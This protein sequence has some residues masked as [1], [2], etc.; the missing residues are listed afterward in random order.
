VSLGP[1]FSFREARLE[2]R[3]GQ[4]LLDSVSFETDAARVA[5][6]GSFAPFVALA[7]DRAVLG[8]GRAEF[9]GR[10][11][12]RA[13]YDNLVG[14]ALHDATFPARTSALDYLTSSARL[15]ALG[16]RDARRESERALES[17]G[18]SALKKKKF[19]ALALAE[20]RALGIAHTTLGSPPAIL[21]E[22]PF[23]GLD[24]AAAERLAAVLDRAADGRRLAIVLS[25]PSGSGPEARYVQTADYVVV[26]ASGRVVTA[27]APA[28][29]LRPSLRYVLFAT[30]G[31][32]AL[33]TLLEERGIGV[34]RLGSASDGAEAARFV[35]ELPEGSTTDVL[36]D[37]ALR[38]EAP[39][40]ELSPIGFIPKIG[41]AP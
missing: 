9:F 37:A 33:S 13:V 29:V 12:A 40:I 24:D 14:V 17:L 23:E 19:D 3:S 15:L 25:S 39:L 10:A 1:F 16:R 28:T 18:L 7:T 32:N 5:L 6:V 38:A 4:V 35:V 11:P 31:A 30:R 21:V 22:R 8:G 27:G 20:H 41:T 26:A 34:R 36:I 2:T